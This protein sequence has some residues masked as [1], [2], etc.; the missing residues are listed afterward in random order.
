MSHPTWV[1]G[2]KHRRIILRSIPVK[3][4]PTWVRGLKPHAWR[5]SASRSESH[6]TWVRGLKQ[7]D[8]VYDDGFLSRTLR[9]CVDWNK[10]QLEVMRVNT[11]SHPTWV[12]G[13]KPL[14][15]GLFACLCLSHPTWVRGLKPRNRK[16]PLL[17]PSRT[18]RGCVDW[19]S[20]RE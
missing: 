12:R 13:L 4:H 7:Y 9:G 19:N 5:I 20:L 17:S 1:R 11:K 10:I 15:W 2:L 16:K 14:T 8:D 3:S 18:L 6:P